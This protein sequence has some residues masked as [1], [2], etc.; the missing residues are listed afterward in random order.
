MKIFNQKELI[1]LITLNFYSILFYNSEIWHLPTLNWNLKKANECIGKGFEGMLEKIDI[2]VS[3]ES[4][5]RMSKRATPKKL[6]KYKLA[7]CLHK[8]YNADFN[9]KEFIRLNVNQILTSRQE[10]YFFLKSNNIKVGINCLANRFYTLNG[11]IPLNWLN[12]TIETFKVKCKKLLI[13]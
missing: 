9:S 5:H 13:K 3:F 6:M 11:L 12:N 10:K 2:H 7:L 1:Q 8:I 4:L